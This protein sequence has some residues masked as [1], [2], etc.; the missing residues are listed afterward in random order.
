MSAAFTESTVEAAALGWL[1]AIGWNIAH[2]PDI[3]PDTLLA[4]RRDYGEV[5]LG[6]RLRDALA[7]LNPGLPAEAL[8][9]AFRKLTRPTGAD[10]LQRNRALHRMLVEGVTVEYRHADGGIR[11]AQA[12]DADFD[13]RRRNDWLAVNQFT[14]VENKHERRPDVVLFVNG[15]PL[16]VLELKNAADEDAT[17]WAAHHQLQ[18]YQAEIG[19]LFQSNAVL[20]I[21][22]GVARARRRAR[23]GPRMVQ[24]VAHGERRGAR[25]AGDAAIA[26][27]DRGGVRQAPVSGPGARLHRLRRRCGAHRQE[28][29][30]L[31]PVS[32]GAGSRAGDAA[33]G[34]VG[35]RATESPKTAG[36]MRQVASRAA[37]PA[38]GAWAWS[39][40]RRARARA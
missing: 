32:R 28:G 16:A 10:L 24:A 34:G 12:R 21:S 3:A 4:E 30:R 2:G 25:A 22:D 13:D 31:P 37:S 36:A 39:G 26:G 5:V 38:T 33:R 29:G 19:A 40:T 23:R 27:G 14:V 18:T 35:P 17:I 15:L 1:Q 7:R 6:A 9:D 11:G 8:E 20:V